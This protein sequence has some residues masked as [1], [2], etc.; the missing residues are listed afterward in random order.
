MIEPQGSV[1]RVV[2]NGLEHRVLSYGD[3]TGPAALILPGITSTAL[4]AEFMALALAERFQVYVPDLRGRGGTDRASDGHYLLDDYAEDVTGLIRTLDL[5]R[6]VI[7]G[8]SLGARIAAAYSVRSSGAHEQLVLVDPPL[9]GPRRAAY[10][11]TRADF[12]AQLQD[13]YRGTT[14][15]E[16][17]KWYPRWPE[18]ELQIRAQELPT[19]DREAVLTTHDNFHREDFFPY[20]R[21]LRQPALLIRGARSPVVT[22]AGAEQLRAANPGIPIVTVADAGHMVPWDN[23]PGFRSQLLNYLFAPTGA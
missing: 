10:P 14:V 21:R 12:D 17:R 18:R 11:T 20:W 3:N 9:S 15:E 2:A 23:W 19:C 13:A 8:H 22:D 1:L 16:L 5:R 4:T 6:P 7:V